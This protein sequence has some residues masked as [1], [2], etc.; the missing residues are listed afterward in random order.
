M[1][2]IR[3]SVDKVRQIHVSSAGM[4]SAVNMKGAGVH[5]S[6]KDKARHSRSYRKSE[7]RKMTEA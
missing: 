7:L 3:V 2:K 1:E 5:M 4:A 6:K